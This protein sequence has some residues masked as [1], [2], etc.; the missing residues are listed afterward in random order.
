MEI[1]YT[2]PHVATLSINLGLVSIC[3]RRQWRR[4]AYAEVCTSVC[5]SAYQSRLDP[6][7]EWG[8][9]GC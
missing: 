9:S 6:G 8:Y 7:N 4:F 2:C 1:S 5:M 3:K